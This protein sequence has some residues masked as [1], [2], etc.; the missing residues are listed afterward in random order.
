MKRDFELVKKIM[1]HIEEHDDLEFD[2]GE[3]DQQ[4]VAY[5][6]AILNEA[7]LIHAVS[8]PA[9]NGTYQLQETG[10]TRLTWE[11]HEFLDAAKN[12]SVWE[13]AKKKVASTGGSVSFAVITKLLQ[14]IVTEALGMK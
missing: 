3:D 2:F 4:L 12:P 1:L 5:H 14:E 13:K 10:S 6:V 7:N 8:V 9:L 11:G